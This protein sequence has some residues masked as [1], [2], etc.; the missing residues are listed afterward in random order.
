MVPHA[1]ECV[2]GSAHGA[3]WCGGGHTPGEGVIPAGSGQLVSVRDDCGGLGAGLG[4]LGPG[5]RP[6][7]RAARRQGVAR[8]VKC[9]ATSIWCSAATG[10]IMQTTRG[11]RD[12]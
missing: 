3:A 5:H 9:D 10:V 11:R 8:V 4:Q 12:G 2:L 6:G 7:Q 1:W